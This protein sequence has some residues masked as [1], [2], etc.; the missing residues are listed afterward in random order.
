MTRRFYT[1]RVVCVE[2]GA[3]RI[4]HA[5]C[6]QADRRAEAHPGENSSRAAPGHAPR[7]PRKETNPDEIRRKIH[8]ARAAARREALHVF[9]DG[10]DREH[11]RRPEPRKPGPPG[12]RAEIERPI[13]K[14]R[15][16]SDEH[17]V[18]NLVEAREARH[19]R[20]QQTKI[21]TQGDQRGQADLRG[22]AD[23]EEP[24]E[25]RPPRLV[26]CARERRAQGAPFRSVAAAFCSWGS[27]PFTQLPRRT[28]SWGKSARSRTAVPAGCTSRK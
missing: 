21:S 7:E 5:T 22:E 27:A 11:E 20:G 8:E 10:R 6:H 4:A 26:R 25:P 17:R 12:Q 3:R 16:Q 15:R 1:G 14:E 18:G 2:S 9:L 13:E 28:C 19:R 24:A 23:P